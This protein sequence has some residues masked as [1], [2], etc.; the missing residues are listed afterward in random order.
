MLARDHQRNMSW[1]LM[2]LTQP[3]TTL[4][5]QES[6]STRHSLHHLK[7]EQQITLSFLFL[8]CSVQLAWFFFW[9]F[10]LL[11]Q[12]GNYCIGSEDCAFLGFIAPRVMVVWGGKCNCTGN[13]RRMRAA[14]FP[15]HSERMGVQ[16]VCLQTYGHVF[17]T[18]L[19]LY[20]LSYWSRFLD[21][22]WLHQ[23]TFIYS[24]QSD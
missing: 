7:R 9:F 20:G 23:L 5:I 13:T 10:F 19:W 18:G 11:S 1:V 4:F 16:T 3:G 8:F 21:W 22:K 6:K 12:S 24:T 14:F 15:R 17:D 2:S